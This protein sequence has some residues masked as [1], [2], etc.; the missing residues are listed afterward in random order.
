M[1]EPFTRA[2]KLDN[3][4]IATRLEADASSRLKNKTVE[5]AENLSTLNKPYDKKVDT[6]L[7]ELEDIQTFTRVSERG[8][9][10]A[11]RMAREQVDVNEMSFCAVIFERFSRLGIKVSVVRSAYNNAP[12]D[13]VLRLEEEASNIC[14]IFESVTEGN[15][16]KKKV[17]AAGKIF[18]TLPT[19]T[20]YASGLQFKITESVVDEKDLLD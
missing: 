19:D 3:F 14:Y 10:E 8:G 16:A 11:S 20:V 6:S 12:D 5:F 17:F 9:P 1:V 18:D 4:V 13:A 2:V 7:G 15:P